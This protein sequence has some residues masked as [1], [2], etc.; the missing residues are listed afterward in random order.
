MAVQRI[1]QVAPSNRLQRASSIEDLKAEL[2]EQHVKM[3]EAL[4]QLSR[5]IDEAGDNYTTIVRNEITS[6]SIPTDHGSLTGLTD[7]D[8]TQYQKE[9]EK[10]AASGY[11]SL[12]S[13]SVVVEKVK[14]LRQG[15][16]AAKPALAEGELYWATDTDTLYIGT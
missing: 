14:L 15:L 9:S 2:W 4:R 13:S 7:D 16:D 1:I 8:H 10:G 12:D 6:G 5:L 3:N 11:A